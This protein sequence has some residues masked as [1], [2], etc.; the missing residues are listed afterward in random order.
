MAINKDCR[1]VLTD[2]Y[3]YDF[4]SAYPRLLESIDWDFGDV[5][6]ENKEQRNIA[7]G[8]AQRNN[9][10]LS[11]FL[12]TAIDNLLTFYLIENNVS[13]DSVIVSQRDGFILTESLSITDNFMKLDFR[14]MISMLIITP[15]RNKYMSFDQ[16]GEV[17]VKGISHYYP[18]LN[19]MYNK[20]GDF[21]LY[22]KS[23]LFSQMERLKNDILS[24]NDKSFYMIPVDDE[25]VIRTLQ[26]QFRI[27]NEH[28]FVIDDIDAEKYLEHYFKEFFEAVYLEN[29]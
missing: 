26:G 19:K 12:M 14:G 6:L 22:N 20:F 7:I 11:S 1:L 13:E 18:A 29:F 16:M 4:K 23:A 25:Y 2:L 24:C 15:D 9:S 10:N 21:S 5:D 3:F 28:S 17:S 8:K 27:P